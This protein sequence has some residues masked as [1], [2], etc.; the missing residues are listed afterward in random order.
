MEAMLRRAFTFLPAAT[1][2]TCAYLGASTVSHLVSASLVAEAAPRPVVRRAPPRQAPPPSKDVDAVIA[3]NM[4]CSTCEPG[5]GAPAAVPKEQLASGPLPLSLI[6]LTRGE[7]G[8]VATLTHTGTGRGGAYEEGDVIPGIGT[9][10]RVGAASLDVV[11]DSSGRVERVSLFATAAPASPRRPE[12]APRVAAAVADDPRVKQVAD[13]SY[14]VERGLVDEVLVDPMKSNPGV[15]LFPV[16]EN[17]QPAGFRL[18]GVRPTTLLGKMGLKN[19]DR[20]QSVNGYDLSTPDKAIEAYTKLRAA[21]NLQIAVN[22][23]GSDVKLEY[24]IR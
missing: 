22:R 21:S 17:G 10:R 11:V 12:A 5:T 23:A 16:S 3:R 14:I 7:S 1:L 18:S 19:G 13:N 6:A 4:F 8:Y 24:S 2:V 20:I 15:R 9:L